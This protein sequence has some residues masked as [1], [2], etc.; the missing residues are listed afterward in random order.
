MDKI[1]YRLV[2]NR[3]KHLNSR[4]MALVQIE[5]YLNSRKKYFTTKVYLKPHQW[6]D[7]RKKV[8]KHPNANELNYLLV[9]MVTEL[10]RK[11]LILWKQGKVVSL[12]SL[13]DK[14]AEKLSEGDFLAFYQKE[15]FK[16]SL[17]PASKKNHLSTLS[18]LRHFRKAIS[19]SDI[20]FEFLTTL[21]AY[22]RS[23]HYHIN[24]IAKHLKHL[25]RYVNVAINKG[26]IDAEDYAFRKY[27]IKTMESKHSYLTPDELEC[28]EKLQLKG[29]DLTMQ[30]SLDAFLFCCYSGLRYSDFIHLSED[31]FKEI[32]G[33]IWLTYTSVK[34]G[35]EARIPLDYLFNGKP[36]FLLEKYKE[37][38]KH[39]F[40]L[41]E[42]SNVNKDLQKLANLA[43]LNK[44]IS[45]H[46]A[47]HTNATLLIYKGV[48][49]T[50]IQKLLGHRNIKTTQ[51]YAHVMDRTIVKD[52]GSIAH[53]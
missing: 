48:N 16:S 43:S 51:I 12:D 50:T 11:E 33:E 5:A 31:N 49:I 26:L 3:K 15:V 4:G 30:K 28:L 19:F 10:E 44:N 53:S 18:V 52:L 34:T 22:L 13:K 39:F 38:L 9:S 23:R 41:K 35:I 25:K 36:L 37:N 42:N 47:R 32:N 17:K 29:S 7:R 40:L 24:T 6:N 14:V 2:F 8:V 46:T 45:F 1:M 21:D 20:T 27:K